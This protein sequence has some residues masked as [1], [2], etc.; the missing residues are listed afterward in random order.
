MKDHFSLSIL[1]GGTF[2]DIVPCS[3]VAEVGL[4]AVRVELPHPV[5]LVTDAVD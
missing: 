4:C 2:V 1:Q 5:R 3:A